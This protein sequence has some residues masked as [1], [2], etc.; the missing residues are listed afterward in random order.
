[1]DEPDQIE[2]SD[3]RLTEATFFF[4]EYNSFSCSETLKRLTWT[5]CLSFSRSLDSSLWFSEVATQSWLRN[6]VPSLGQTCRHPE[7]CKI[8][9]LFNSRN[10]GN[11]Y[12]DGSSRYQNRKKSTII[13]YKEDIMASACLPVTWGLTSH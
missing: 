4:L 9:L 1:M 6:T 7:N 3:S 8:Q 5:S 10:Q 2:L 13:F 11:I 12:G